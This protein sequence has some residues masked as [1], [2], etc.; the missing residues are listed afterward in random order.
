MEFEKEQ[1]LKRVEMEDNSDAIAEI[2][3]QRTIE[4]A[5]KQVANLKQNIGYLGTGGQ[6]GI[7]NQKLDAVSNQVSLADRTLKNIIEVER[8]QKENREVGQQKNAEIFTRQL[9]ILQDDLDGK[10]NKKV[11]GALNEFTSAELA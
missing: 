2:N 9:K 5:Q 7:S 1:E 8:L 11:Q 3:S 4:E 10:V 6:P